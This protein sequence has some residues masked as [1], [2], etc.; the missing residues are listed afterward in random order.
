[1]KKVIGVFLVFYIIFLSISPVFAYEPKQ[2]IRVAKFSSGNYFISED[3]GTVKSY[4]K[5]YLDKI[6]EYTG[7]QYEFVDCGTWQ[8]AVKMLENHQIDLV[9]TMQTNDE[10]LQKYDFCRYEY[11]VTYSSLACLPDKNYTFQDYTSFSNASIGCTIDYVRMNELYNW[12]S[13]HN[14]TGSLTFYDTEPELVDALQNGEIDIMAASVHTFLPEW[15]IL[16]KYC[17]SP[18]YFTTWKG[19]SNLTDM[20]DNAIL[21]IKLYESEFQDS[22]AEDYFTYISVDPLTSEEK[23]YIN[24]SSSIE[25]FFDPEAAPITFLDKK[26]GNMKGVIIDNCELISQS[27]GLKIQ[28]KSLVDRELIDDSKNQY[29]F[30][31]IVNNH[32]SEYT[33]ESDN[34]KI[35]KPIFEFPFY[36]YCNWGFDYNVN[37]SYTLAMTS[38]RPAIKDYLEHTYPNYKIIE[39]NTIK[40]CFDLL[41]SEKADLVFSSL[42]T[43]NNILIKENRTDVN[44]IPTTETNIGIAIKFTGKDSEILKSI[45]NKEIS[46]IKSEDQTQTLLNYTTNMVPE[47]SLSYFIQTNMGVFIFIL[48]LIFLVLLFACIWLLRYYA[49]SKQ[50]AALASINN[51]LRKAN[52]AKTEFLS[53][54]S[55][56]IRTPMNAIIG[57]TDLAKKGKNVS[58]ETLDYL[59]KINSSSNFLLGLINDILDMSKI[60]SGSLNFNP[61]TYFYNDF[62]SNINAM[63]TPLCN[64]K[65]LTLTIERGLTEDTALFVDKVRF[66]QIFFNILSNAI[67]YTPSGGKVK[68]E[69]KNISIINKKLSADY[70]ISDNG[71]GMSEEF[72]KEMFNPFAREHD[73]YN[74]V[75]GTGLGLAIT[76]NILD[77]M[78][79][80][81]R[82]S[83][84]EGKGTTVIIHL[85]IPLATKKQMNTN[86]NNNNTVCDLDGKKVLLVEDH[87]LNTE[88]AEKIL[89]N[90]G[91]T[92]VSA[93]NGLDG[94]NKFQASDQYEFDAIL[95]DIRM[96]V[97]NGLEATKNIRKLNRSDAKN[98]PIIAMSANAYQEDIEKSLSAGINEHLAKPINPEL[99][100][101]TLEKFI[102]KNK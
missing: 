80:N 67:K 72:Q 44:F 71:I 77:L 81:I 51:E 70:I 75:E 98:I 37:S 95:M 89:E 94:L 39:C 11:G 60:E 42:Y 76:K 52:A 96:P 13:E 29:A 5:E 49:M 18:F 10:R 17:F 9:G 58:E 45:F 41:E 28:Y 14:I 2:V 101:S 23:Y 55:H 31:S 91:I 3:D 15:N 34:E 79:G 25:L 66:N 36:L 74:T 84:E 59:K 22:L 38:G 30:I 43:A 92:V 62:L 24:N 99:L 97:M 78:G 46:A 4:D 73:D 86:I 32:A 90:K 64:K 65:N 69:M 93:K 7:M 8:N 100:Y 40:E 20:I 21:K 6:S 27:T 26:S 12:M 83:S 61:T 88:I 19:N 16:D 47:A 35:T 56:D 102:G 82:V 50:K 1:M 63:F 57:M 87:P 53:R 48:F 85:D 68:Y 33:K 54:M